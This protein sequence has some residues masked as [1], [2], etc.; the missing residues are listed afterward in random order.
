[1]N[2]I[3]PAA[4]LAGLF[5][6]WLR[7]AARM[8][9]PRMTGP[10]TLRFRLDPGPA[11][12]RHA[13][14]IRYPEFGGKLYC[15]TL[16][17]RYLPYGDLHFVMSGNTHQ[18]T[19]GESLW[20]AVSDANLLVPNEYWRTAPGYTPRKPLWAIRSDTR[21]PGAA[22]VLEEL[23][24]ARARET[25]LPHFLYR[26]GRHAYCN[27]NAPHRGEFYS[28]NPEGEWSLHYHPVTYPL[29]GTPSTVP[30]RAGT[31]PVSLAWL[32]NMAEPP[33]IR[34]PAGSS[35]VLP[36]VEAPGR[37]PLPR[38]ARPPERFTVPFR[39]KGTSL[40]APAPAPHPTTIPHPTTKEIPMPEPA[41]IPAVTGNASIKASSDPP[42]TD[43]PWEG[44]HAE[45][46]LAPD[47]ARFAKAAGL[48]QAGFVI[49]INGEDKDRE[50]TVH[51][52]GRTG[53]VRIPDDVLEPAPP[54]PAVTTSHGEIASIETAEALLIDSAARVRYQLEHGGRPDPD[55]D[56]DRTRLAKALGSMC[57]LDPHELMRQLDPMIG[58]QVTAYA[59]ART[60]H[61]ASRKRAA[62]V[63]AADI[64]KTRK[65]QAQAEAAPAPA[66]AAKN[67]AR[68]TTAR[69][70]A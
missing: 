38:A 61:P 42:P 10:R 1:M 29:D 28:V 9:S 7:D 65:P 60:R 37:A 66:P 25:G 13:E 58:Q 3:L 12:E 21:Q 34:R 67:G 43:D 69:A 59:Q 27:V 48:A 36:V 51:F 8:A 22:R 16:R 47:A 39:A 64:P 32:R 4:A 5:P 23:G 70:K 15:L 57:G 62:A 41:A 56:Q 2:A 55:A 33:A 35:R 40:T 54:F 53:N 68:R 26:Q 30:G 18:D 50:C 45:V 52:P 63:A 31:H 44:A 20:R 6:D 17:Q 24:A 14:L 46:R 49:G 19:L 11:F